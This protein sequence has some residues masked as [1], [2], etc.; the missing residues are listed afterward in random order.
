[1]LVEKSCPSFFGASVPLHCFFLFL[2]KPFDLYI[3]YIFSSTKSTGVGEK[4]TTI[5][6]SSF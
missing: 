4:K 5:N 6:L 2:V 3:C 1:M